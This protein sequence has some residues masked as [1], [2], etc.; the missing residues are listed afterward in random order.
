MRVRPAG[1]TGPGHDAEHDLALTSA[2]GVTGRALLLTPSRGI[3]GGIERYVETLEWA[4]TA[5]GV[6]Y[7]RID[8]IRPGPAAHARMLSRAHAQL[9]AERAPTRLVVAHRALLPVASLLARERPVSGISVMCYGTDVWCGTRLRPRWWVERYLMRR[10]GVRVVAISSFT[11]GV[12]AHGSPATILVP[13]LS[14][15]WFH[16]LVEASAVARERE[17]GLNL[18]TAFRLGDWRDKGLPQLLD[19]VAALGRSDIR[20]T[21]CGSGQP[22]A[23]L[24]Q[25][26]LE[27]PYCALRP[28][29]TDRE[30]ACE[31]AAADLFVLAT[32]TRPGRNASGEGFGLVL[33]EAQVAGTPV[34]GPAYGGSHDAFID[35]VTGVAPANETTAALTMLLGDLLRDPKRLARMGRSA[36]ELSRECFAPDSYA[37]RVVARLL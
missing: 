11:A 24:Q 26:V 12:L 2:R 33:L 9:R 10:P 35:G 16:T 15:E 21:V 29:L 1:P 8:L 22:P 17:P 28:G 25:L 18:L 30:L 36:A 19:A 34:V 5:Q 37:S 31:L 13:G 20:V 3:G 7:Q 23:D 27:R 32:R 6:E 4:F 14:R